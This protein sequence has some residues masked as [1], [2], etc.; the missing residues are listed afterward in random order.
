MTRTSALKHPEYSPLSIVRMLWKRKLP[1]VAGWLLLSAAS[2]AVVFKLPP[3]YIADTLILIDSQ[4]IPERFVPST[5]SSPVQ[6]R[7]TAIS[8]QIM[9]S[10]R[11][12]S[13]IDE[14]NLYRDQKN[15]AAPEE[16][17]DMMRADIKI[18]TEQT[19][20]VTAG[21]GHLGAFRVGYEGSDPTVVAQVANRLANLYIE[22]NLKTR[23]VQ[24]EGTSEFMDAQTDEARKRLD[25][26]EKTVG[27]WK[28]QHA[29]EL[30]E[31]E[32]AIIAMINRLQTDLQM[33]TAAI[34]RAQ[35]SRTMLE[36]TREGA[37]NMATLLENALQRRSNPPQAPKSAARPGE[38]QRKPSE[39]LQ[40][41]IDLLRTH[42]G[43]DHPE[44]KRLRAGL[45][46]L[47][48]REL[49]GQAVHTVKVDDPARPEEAAPETAS[50][51]PDTRDLVDL[52]QARQ[53]VTNVKAQLTVLDKELEM[54][55][56]DQ[57]RILHSLTQYQARIEKLPLR[58]Q[59]MARLTRDY[60]ISKANYKS[61]LDKKFSA[62]MS[63]DMERRQKSERFTIIDAARVPT[64]PVKPN[65]PLLSGLCSLGALILS[66]V[67]VLGKEAQKSVMLGEWEL[68]AGTVVLARLPEIGLPVV[69]APA[70]NDPGKRRRLRWILYPSGLLLLVGV[71]VSAFLGLRHL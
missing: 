57:E 63:T 19:R 9:S 66:L 18:T 34:A 33:N 68:P 37:E 35:E 40:A 16:I 59:E 67:L 10:T 13:V 36:S 4:K 53:R 48:Q 46:G 61:L 42:Y 38:A 44:I 3:H 45:E 60:E 62:E 51:A 29:G 17:L 21:K 70:E 23:E 39:L 24:S 7:I 47:K 2:V 31:Q 15:S 1:I 50:L 12:K 22:E 69:K 65:R 26:L 54:R 30:P 43:D 8:Q 71:A 11:L 49:E 56:G 14:F 52:G 5:V 41:Q 64:V 32:A 28:Q 58:Q 55:K 6:E 27:D 20:G 25:E